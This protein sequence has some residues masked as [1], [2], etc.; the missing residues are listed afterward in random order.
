MTIVAI[1]KDQWFINGKITYPGT[2]CEGLLMNVRMVNCTFED[3]HR[4]DFDPQENTERFIAAMPDYYRHGVC[5]FTLC[6]QGGMPGYEGA[7]NSAFNRDG[8][9]RPD[10][11]ARVKRVID[12]CDSQGIVA[13]LGCYYQRQDEILH[14]ATAIRAGVRNTVEWVKAEGFAH[15]VLEV[16]NE[17]GHA[18]FTHELFKTNEGQVELVQLAKDAYPELLV[19]TSGQAPGAEFDRLEKLVDFNLVHLNTTPLE[20]VVSKIVPVKKYGKPVICNEDDKLGVD[21][22]K[23]AELCVE[24]GVS[25]GLMQNPV[26]QTYPFCFDGRADDPVIYD[27]L[28]ELAGNE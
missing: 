7:V 9:L 14:D 16:A 5:A 8:S 18:G 21:G 24:Q 1:E 17:F 10:Y 27:K 13:I 4:T 20:K 2:R 11:L 3:T 19:S 15:V 23:C 26:N 12:E 28:K 6:L 22:A 25:W